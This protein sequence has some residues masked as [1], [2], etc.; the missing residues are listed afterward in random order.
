MQPDNDTHPSATID[1]FRYRGVTLERLEDGTVAWRDEMTG[2]SGTCSGLAQ[3]CDLIAHL[4]R[5]VRPDPRAL[6]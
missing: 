4:H 2:H 3:L 5:H 6:S 1:S